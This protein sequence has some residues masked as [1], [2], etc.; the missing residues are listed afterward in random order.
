ME[1]QRKGWQKPA[2][3]QKTTDDDNDD[4]DDKSGSGSGFRNFLT[5]FFLMNALIER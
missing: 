2:V 5:D 4:D 1:T 3:L